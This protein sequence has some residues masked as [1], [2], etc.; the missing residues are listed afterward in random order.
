MDALIAIIVGGLLMSA[1]SLFGAVTFLLREETLKKLLLP[2]VALAAGSMLGGALFHMLPGGVESMGNT[3]EL[4]FWVVAGFATFFFLEQ[5]LHW[6][7]CHKAPSE[8]HHPMTTLLLAADLLHNLIGGLAIGGS[9]VI[10]VKLGAA[11]W[12][13]AA[14]HELPQE[15][16][17]FGV[18]V[19]GGYSKGKALLYNFLTS[20]T[21]PLGALIAYAVSFHA[22]VSFLLPFAAGNF[23]YIGAADLVP[24]INKHERMSQNLLHLASFLTGIL[25]LLAVRLVFEH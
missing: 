16:G 2:M 7:H 11:A 5:F 21:F 14:A 6:H 19:H 23:L 15:L 22:D 13:A 12:I 17:D 3:T 18:L 24:E 1:I 4:Y 25:L 9:F 10:D 8:H 20:L